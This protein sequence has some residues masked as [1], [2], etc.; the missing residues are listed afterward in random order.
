MRFP[1]RGTSKIFHVK[2]RK[3]C[4]QNEKNGTGA[5]EHSIL[6]K[7]IKTR[8]EVLLENNQNLINLCL[9][10]SGIPS[11]WNNILMILIY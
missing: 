10:D 8:E 2:S 7:A 9:S 3:I 5:G 11:N 1:L 4:S 6:I